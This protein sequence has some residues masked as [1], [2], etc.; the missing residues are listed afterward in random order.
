MFSD[1]GRFHR[2]LCFFVPSFHLEEVASLLKFPNQHAIVR[3]KLQLVLVL[4]EG[5]GDD[6]NHPGV[7]PAIT[8]ALKVKPIVEVQVLGVGEAFLIDPI[9]PLKVL[10]DE[11]SHPLVR[12]RQ[13]D[14][15]RNERHSV[16]LAIV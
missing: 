6:S 13:V 14:L 1:F 4:D 8:V 10:H 11:P 12:L 2:K 15:R 16:Y 5:H 7:H 9:L 3:L